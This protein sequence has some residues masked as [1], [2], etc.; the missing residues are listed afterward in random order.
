MRKNVAV[1]RRMCLGAMALIVLSISCSSERPEPFFRFDDRLDEAVA[2]KVSAIAEAEDVFSVEFDET[3]TSGW[4]VPHNGSCEVR[5]GVLVASMQ[6]LAFVTGPDNLR[7]DTSDAQSLLIRMKLAGVESVVLGWEFQGEKGFSDQNRFRIYAPR[8]DRWYIYNIKASELNGWRGGGRLLDRMRIMVPVEAEVHLDFIRLQTRRAYFARSEVGV[9]QHPINNQ[10][11]TCLY[12]HCPGEIEYKVTIPERACLR[13]GVGIVDPIPPV[14]FTVT[15]KRDGA[16]KSLFSRRVEGN[17]EWHDANIDMAEYA[18]E[19]LDLVFK[20]HCTS[21]GNVALWSNP[22]LYQA[23]PS[24]KGLTNPP[25]R[26]RN[27]NVVLYLIDAL[28]ADHL[29]IYGYA[30]DTAP[31]ITRLAGE[32]VR[33]ARCFSQETWTKPSI[34]SLFSGATAWVHGV[35]VHC[36]TVPHSMVLLP[37]ILRSHGYATAS[38]SL[39][40]SIG[41]LTGLTR[42]FSY[43]EEDYL[44]KRSDWS[45]LNE[46]DRGLDHLEEDYLLKHYDWLPQATGFLERCKDRNFFLYVHTIEPHDPYRPPTRL[47]DLFSPQ[48]KEPADVDLYDAEIMHADSNLAL[49]ISKLK[50]LGMYDDTLLIITADHGEAFREHEGITLHGSKPYNELIH[51]PL[52]VRLPGAVPGGRVVDHNVQLIDIAPTI[53]DALNIHGNEQFQGMSLLPLITGGAADAFESRTVYS[54][55]KGVTAAIRRDWK[56]MRSQDGLSLYDL[57]TD[58]GETK[59]VAIENES[60]VRSLEEELSNYLAVQERIARQIRASTP[61]GEVP[62]DVDPRAIEQLKALGYLK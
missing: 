14:E 11:R 37:E 2:T 46:P 21:P 42:G 34:P 57:S 47:V 44:L 40:S 9:T 3:G 58:F 60:I 17:E 1:R 50:E 24:G 55:G 25:L 61:D 59:S 8:P 45:I 56:L 62:L 12:A 16:A 4:T 6:G 23:N 53:L 7:I 54:A 26:G 32:G 13:V 52:I 18:N 43:F 48:G 30:R 33:F 36:D 19:E 41:P 28:R 51:I 38:I 31:T 15:A 35:R 49:L 39:N 22:I 20:S 10:V 5:D 27:L 29:D